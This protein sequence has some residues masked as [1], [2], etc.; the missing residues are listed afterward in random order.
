MSVGCLLHFYDSKKGFVRIKRMN[1]LL[2][3]HYAGSP[4]LG[5]EF[6]PYY[7][8]REWVKRG[9][10]VDIIAADYSHLRTSNPKIKHDFEEETVDGIHYHWI[11][12]IQYE[13]N[14]AKRAFTMAQFVG[15]IW[16]NARKIAKKFQ[17]DTIITS[18]TYPI[19]TF[20]GQRIKKMS[21]KKVRLIHEVHDMWPSTL[22]EVG[23]MSKKHPFVRVMQLGEDSAY[24]NSDKVVS[25]LPY[26][27]KY[28]RKHG[29]KKGKFVCIPNGIVEEEWTHPKALTKSHADVLQN[30]KDEGDF[31]VGYFGGHALS[32]ALDILLD[33]A[34]NIKNEPIQF[35]LVGDGVEKPRLMKRAEKE[36]IRNVNFLPSVP[37]AEVA[38]LCN[39]FDCIFY[40]VLPSP[41][42][43]FGMC[44]NKM[45]DSMRAGK[46]N[47]CALPVKHCYV[48][49]YNCGVCVAP[50]V[51]KIIKGIELIRSMDDVDLR[52]MGD[53]G[54]K[55]AIK[56]FNYTLLSEKFL[57]IME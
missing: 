40:C 39:Y 29:L 33:V 52:N 56:N 17:P 53:R 25:L 2:I 28:M 50:E 48:E 12:T 55:A 36:K 35:V 4:A 54:K 3:N 31:I 11:K 34:K 38:S 7:F 49:E 32:N 1:I 37:K 41:L 24:R 10:R 20:A 14:G 44:L 30:I 23:G 47:L 9:H 19:D 5:M 18:S 21:R 22:Y 51:D 43:R 46:V 15:K 16:V 57:K 26:A 27:E 8:A 6:R 42:Y 45:F 13:G